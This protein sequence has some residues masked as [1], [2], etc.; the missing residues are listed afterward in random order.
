[1]NITADA[2]PAGKV[3]STWTSTPAVTFANKNN[4]NTS[5]TMPASAVTITATYKT[6]SSGSNPPTVS[7]ITVSNDGFGT[8]SADTSS[9]YAGTTINLTAVPND[10]YKF[11]EWQVL[12]GGVT[13]TDNQF[14]MPAKAVSVKAIFELVSVPADPEPDPE[15]EPEGDDGNL[16]LWAAVGCLVLIVLLASV[17]VLYRRKTS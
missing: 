8:A 15:P 6:S 4:A 1:V 5:F 13:I 14:T 10:G 17:F 9:A 16:M 12:A 3:F 7:A 11:K 2:A